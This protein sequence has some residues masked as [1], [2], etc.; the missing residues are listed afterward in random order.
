MTLSNQPCTTSNPCRHSHGALNRARTIAPRIL[1][2]AMPDLGRQLTTILGNAGFEV[3]RTPDA[4]NVSAVAR[5]LQPQLLIV[6]G[7]LPIGDG[8]QI[9]QRLRAELQRL[10]VLILDRTIAT[11]RSL[12]QDAASAMLIAAVEEGLSRRTGPTLRAPLNHFPQSKQ[13]D[14]DINE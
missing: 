1:I 8:V 7:E 3:H 6:A 9:V 14:H 5:Q 12:Q 2:L 4:A 10:P 11:A 13:E